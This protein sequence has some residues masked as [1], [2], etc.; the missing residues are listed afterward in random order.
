MLLW[1]VARRVPLGVRLIFATTIEAAW[2]LVENSPVIIERYRAAT[3]A[4]GYSG[5]SIINSVSDICF[6]IVGFLV[7]SRLP[8]WGTVAL[9]VTLELVALAVIR[10]NLT[11]NVLM[12]IHPIEAIRVW[13]NG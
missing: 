10:D 7:A 12:L 2:E 5:D 1:L 8:A 9:G 13:Q 3:M 11:L 6:M 4:L